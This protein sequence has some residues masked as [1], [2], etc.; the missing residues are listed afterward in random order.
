[1]NMQHITL[2][3]DSDTLKGAKEMPQRMSASKL[4]RHSI[5]A[6]TY[7]AKQW[8]EYRK[9]PE[10]KDCLEFLRPIRERFVGK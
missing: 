1:M 4:F 3:V 10:C 2:T 5:K 8:A 9:T 6:N 7:N